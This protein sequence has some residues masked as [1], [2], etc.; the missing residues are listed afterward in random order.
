MYTGLYRKEN[1]KYLQIHITKLA[2]GKLVLTQ[3]EQN[4]VHLTLDSIF[5]TA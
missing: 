5:P 3:R 2:F 4:P 1:T